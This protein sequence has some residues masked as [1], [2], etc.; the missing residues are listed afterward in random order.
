MLEVVSKPQIRL[1]IKASHALECVCPSVHVVREHFDA[2][3]NAAIG[4]QMGF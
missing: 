3:D 4:P 2:R 1:C